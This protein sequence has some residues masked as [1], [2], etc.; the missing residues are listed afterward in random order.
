MITSFDQVVASI[1]AGRTN[2]YIWHKQTGSAAYTAGRWYNTFTLGGSPPA[3]TYPGTALAAVAC[4]ASTTGWLPYGP[5]VEPTYNRYLS[6]IE[7]HTPIA[8][9]VPS[10]LML[11]DILL[12]YPG[13]DMNS[14][15]TQLLANVA[16]LPRY[17]DG[18]GVQMFL[19][20]NTVTGATAHSLHQTGFNYTAAGDTSGRVLPIT[21]ACTASAIA[22]HIVHSGVAANNFG[23]FIPPFGSDD[24]VKSVQNFQLTS[25]SGS[26]GTA[27]LVL[28]KLL[29][30]IPLTTVFV[31][32]SRDFIFNMPWFPRVYDGACLSFLV[33]TGGAVAPS[34]NFVANLE[35]VW[36]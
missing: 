4:D 32:S 23:P 2:R 19:E 30:V 20:A 12:Y 35:F 21:V 11:V 7:V 18:I 26:V 25:F 9:G 29:A 33:L 27:T 22:P 17:T 34:T 15:Q 13:I 10:W 28:C 1:S 14:G 24:G 36:G 5:A 6:S 8:T 3:A 16:A 31:A